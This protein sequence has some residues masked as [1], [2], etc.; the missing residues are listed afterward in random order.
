MN[1]EPLKAGHVLAMRD[2]AMHGGFLSL[3][4]TEHLAGELEACGG[5][6]VSAG[7][8]VVA[9]GGIFQMRP[10]CGHAWAWLARE[11]RGHARYI[12]RLV[13]GG[14]DAAEFERVEAAVKC[15]FAAGHRWLVR[16]GF[17]CEAER[18]RRWA[19]DGDYALYARVRHG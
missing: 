1:V 5:W 14:L 4:V 17:T 8:G 9:L 3:P 10:G 11:W 12:T 18:M 16:L 15:E 6:A 2:R 19:P 7:G 13:Q